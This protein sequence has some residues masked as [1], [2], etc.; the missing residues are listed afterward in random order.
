MMFQKAKRA[1]VPLKIA[2]SGASGSGKTRSAL[3]LARGLAGDG[4]RIAVVDT[5]NGSASLYSDVADFDVCNVEPNYRDGVPQFWAPQIANALTAAFAADYSVVV[6][7]SA[8]HVWEATLDYKSRLDNAGGNGYTN[9]NAAGKHWKTTISLILQA[10]ADVIC[11]FRSKTEYALEKNEAGKT[12]PIKIG[13]APVARDGADYEF[14][15]WL[16]LDRSHRATATKD[17]TTLFSE[18]EIIT[19]ETGRRLGAWRDGLD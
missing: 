4:G 7:D 8:S 2:L 19:V 3:E 5:E 6:L 11:C 14:S 12:V 13:T 1:S 10:R 9:W 16:E 15:V 18:P 17:R